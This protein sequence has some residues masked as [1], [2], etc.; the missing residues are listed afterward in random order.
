MQDLEPI[1]D[2]LDFSMQVS[3]KVNQEMDLMFGHLEGSVPLYASVDD[4]NIAKVS[5]YVDQSHNAKID[6]IFGKTTRTDKGNYEVYEME[7]KDIMSELQMF[8]KIAKIP[9]VVP[10]GLYVRDGLVF[11]EFR[12]HNSALNLMGDLIKEINQ[13]H[14]RLKLTFLGQS[15]GLMN[16]LERVN[17]KIPLSFINFSF[18]P[19]HDY[20]APFKLE[21]KP[22]AELK[23]F[24][25]GLNSE[26]DIVHYGTEP[27]QGTAAQSITNGIYE[28]KLRTTFMRHF[29][30]KIR[31]NKVPL[32]SILGLYRENLL[33]NYMTVPTFLADHVLSLLFDTAEESSNETLR[34]RSFVPWGNRN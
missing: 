15:A 24:S 34:L 30:D 1:S 9:S 25:N 7:S 27:A 10:V 6:R 12:F 5:I 26:Y 11:A 2:K 3:M 28:T 21:E 20:I 23:I 18:V 31:E 32:I 4:N 13:A 16:T 19:N 29:N 14:N 17:S 22:V 33:E 8:R